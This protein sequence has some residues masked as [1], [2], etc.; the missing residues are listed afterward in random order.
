VKKSTMVYL[1]LAGLG[2]YLFMKHRAAKKMAGMGDYCGEGFIQLPDGTC[3]PSLHTSPM[4]T[5]ATPLPVS[6]LTPNCPPG[7]SIINDVCVPTGVV[8]PPPPPPPEPVPVPAPTP[9][10]CSSGFYYDAGA[11]MCMPLQAACADNESRAPNGMC[12]ID[13]NKFNPP[14]PVLP[15]V[16]A[17]DQG[18]CPPGTQRNAIVGGCDPIIVPKPTPPVPSPSQSPC[19]PGKIWNGMYCTTCPS[20]STVSYAGN[21]NGV[22]I[23]NAPP[24][25]TGI[26]SCAQG[27]AFSNTSFANR[28]KTQPTLRTFSLNETAR[29][30]TFGGI[31]TTLGGLPY[32]QCATK[33]V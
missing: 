28:R 14:A 7:S 3:V 6:P 26:S 29:C 22:C 8:P 2:L 10:S 12:Y 16:P 17:P 1:G 32:C 15:P 11:K 13:I 25:V 31:V 33:H 18:A 20:G 30:R 24:P 27:A 9:T 4:A 23:P 5:P 19:P 21:P